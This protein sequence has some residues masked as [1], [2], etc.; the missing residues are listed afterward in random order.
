M[1]SNK[2]PEVFDNLSSE[3]TSAGYG[4][5]YV[6]KLKSTGTWSPGNPSMDSDIARIRQK[7]EP[8]VEKGNEII[9]VLHSAGGFLGSNAFEGLSEKARK[10]EGLAGGVKGIVFVSAAIY[11][12][13]F[14][15]GD[16]P[17][18]MV[19]VSLKFRVL[20]L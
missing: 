2:G 6:V 19:D 18:A 16:L 14:H 3:L 1:L 12:E 15:H 20:L 17:F 7:L 9:M 13:G 8:F 11:P 5:V 10:N 4:N